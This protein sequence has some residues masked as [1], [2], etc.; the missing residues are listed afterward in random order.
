LLPPS[1]ESAKEVVV[2]LQKGKKLIPLQ[3]CTGPK[4]SRRLRHPDFRIIGT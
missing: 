4:G 3:A 1:S 2:V